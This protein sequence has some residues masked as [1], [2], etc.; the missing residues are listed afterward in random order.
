[1]NTENP[2][3]TEYGAELEVMYGAIQQGDAIK[4]FIEGQLGR[5]IND[6]LE[7]ARKAACDKLAIIAPTDA[8]GITVLQNRIRVYDTFWKI[9]MEGLHQADQV[10]KELDEEG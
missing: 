5:M 7:S 8:M 10:Q 4:A 3:V 1:M 9:L 6:N 2:T